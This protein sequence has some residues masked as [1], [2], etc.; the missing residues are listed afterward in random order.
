MLAIGFDKESNVQWATP[1]ETVW[2]GLLNPDRIRDGEK[3]NESHARVV[4]AAA[5]VFAA[6]GRC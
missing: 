2:G 3:G 1:F 5:G 4:G 6:G